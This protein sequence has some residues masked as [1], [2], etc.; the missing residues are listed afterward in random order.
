MVG[1]TKSSQHFTSP[2][3]KSRAAIII[4]NNKIDAVL[5]KQLSNPDSVL[6]ELKYN[7]TRF[8]AASVYFDKKEVESELD[9]I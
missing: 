2:V 7:N 3:D 4:I 1:L 8:F 6:I 5:I 9:K